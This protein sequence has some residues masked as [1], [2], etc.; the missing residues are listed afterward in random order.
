MNP[1]DLPPPPPPPARKQKRKLSLKN[2]MRLASKAEDQQTVKPLMSPIDEFSSV[3]SGAQQDME[4]HLLELQDDI[5]NQQAQLKKKETQLEARE[6]EL[7]EKEALLTAK[8]QMLKS[9]VANRQKSAN[10]ANFKKENEALEK[11]KQALDS[12]EKSLKQGRDML[13]EREAYVEQCENALVEQSMLLT[14]REAR[15]EQR[16]EDFAKSNCAPSKTQQTPGAQSCERDT[17]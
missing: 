1:N 17:P 15:I 16:E 3:Q 9:G 10:T 14:E 12:Q 7:N 11:L 8:Q 13:H 4:A 2:A 6:R 5:I